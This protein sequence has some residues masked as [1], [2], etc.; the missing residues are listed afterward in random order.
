MFFHLCRGNN[1]SVIIFH[2]FHWREILF[3]E[4]TTIIV[5][6]TRHEVN[7]FLAE[8]ATFSEVLVVEVFF[9]S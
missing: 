5:T 1:Y 2:V 9:P 6:P 3:I 8:D 4:V 7:L